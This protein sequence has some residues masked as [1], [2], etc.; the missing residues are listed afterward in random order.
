MEGQGLGGMAQRLGGAG[1]AADA[2]GKIREHHVEATAA[3]AMQEGAV[4]GDGQ[5]WSP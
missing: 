3:E 5:G 4:P 1:A 2:A